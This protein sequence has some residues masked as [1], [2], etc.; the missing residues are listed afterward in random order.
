M[1]VDEGPQ[2]GTTAQPKAQHPTTARSRNRPLQFDKPKDDNAEYIAPRVRVTSHPSDKHSA[3]YLGVPPEY[4]L[5]FRGRTGDSPFWGPT[6]FAV[7]DI[8][9]ALLKGVSEAY[10][11]TESWETGEGRHAGEIARQLMGEIMGRITLF[12]DRELERLATGEN[13]LDPLRGRIYGKL[14]RLIISEKGS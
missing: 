13:S 10:K 6:D 5:A 14:L 3:E 12:P 11:N 9:A 7:D 2:E 4:E 8:R 1:D